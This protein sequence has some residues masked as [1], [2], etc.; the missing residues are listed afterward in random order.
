MLIGRR[1]TAIEL[2][3]GCAVYRAMMGHFLLIIF[4]C[5]LH[6]CMSV[7]LSHTRFLQQAWEAQSLPHPSSLTIDAQ[8]KDVWSDLSAHLEY[9]KRQGFGGD[10]SLTPDGDNIQFQGG[11]TDDT[12]IGTIHSDQILHDTRM[13]TKAIISDFSV[14]PFTINEVEAGIPKGNIRY[15]VSAAST[16]EESFRDFWIEMS[17][18][19]ENDN[20]AVSTVL[21]MY[22]NQDLFL[23]DIGLF[24]VYTACLD[25]CLTHASL[26][27]EEE[28]Q[29]VYFHP[30]F[31]FRD[32][33]AQ[34]VMVF[35][36]DGTPLG[37]SSEISNPIDYSRRSP[38]PTINILRAPQVNK[39]QNGVP[40]GQIFR[41][42]VK[43]LSS[44]GVEK[45]QHM[46]EKRD[47]STL[48]VISSHAKRRQTSSGDSEYTNTG[49]GEQVAQVVQYLTDSESSEGPLQ[50][51]AT[52]ATA[53]TAASAA[54]SAVTAVVESRE[55]E[56]PWVEYSTEDGVPY[57]HNPATGETA[58][59]VPQSLS[60]P[61]DIYI[62][63][64]IERE[65][66]L[67]Q[68]DEYRT[69]ENVPYYHNRVSGETVW[70][71]PT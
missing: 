43:N 60:L 7:K 37:L 3:A 52:S 26:G 6:A 48:P 45:L 13:W 34:N 67:Q 49:E 12:L 19:L 14:C 55:R 16:V 69:E 62:P 63:V 53:S 58:W 10:S 41:N 36:D 68:W 32:K 24:E 9:C 8:V 42:N 30:Q 38:Y 5:G 66:E 71:V 50:Q 51:S 21:L 64:E 59:E 18:I 25:D 46:L 11:C 29:L 15:T 39:V 28:M 65:R 54:A 17:A 56:Q 31:Q 20:E 4:I 44:I 33:D 70:E 2:R 40:V 27:I 23:E 35:A 47:W 61:N 22:A 57:Y 1:T